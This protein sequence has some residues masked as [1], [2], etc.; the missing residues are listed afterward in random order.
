MALAKPI[1]TSLGELRRLMRLWAYRDVQGRY[2]SFKGQSIDV[3]DDED[4]HKWLRASD[5]RQ[6]VEHFPRDESLLQ[7]FGSKAKTLGPVHDAWIQAEALH[8]YLVRSTQTKSIRFK[9]WLQ[10]EVI[11][12]SDKRR[13][14][15]S[16]ATHHAPESDRAP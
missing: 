2:H 14:A 6:V 16:P 3:M 11:L 9:V 15:K 4:D 5:V 13:N 7:L 8:S 12:P 1:L 10:R